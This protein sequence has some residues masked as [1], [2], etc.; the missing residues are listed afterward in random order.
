MCLKLKS[1]NVLSAVV[2]DN[3]LWNNWKIETYWGKV[4][5]AFF[6]L[7]ITGIKWFYSRSVFT[8]L[9]KSFCEW[10]E[11]LTKTIKY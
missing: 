11:N 4:S 5:K 10:E 8:H 7:E 6:R 3:A 1:K 9:T 2:Q